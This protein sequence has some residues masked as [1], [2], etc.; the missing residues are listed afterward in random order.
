MDTMEFSIPEHF[1]A[2]VQTRIR[3]GGFESASEYLQRLIE[4]DE[5]RQARSWLDAELQKG[6]ENGPAEPM[7]AEDWESLRN[8]VRNRIESRV[9]KSA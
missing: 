9:N 2:F 8:E 3:E 4:A 6:I 5:R 7:T 1:R